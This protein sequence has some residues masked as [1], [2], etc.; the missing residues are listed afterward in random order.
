MSRALFITFEGGEGSGKTVQARLL[1]ERLESRGL[2]VLLTR[3]PGGT[4]LGDRLREILLHGRDIPLGAEAQALLFFAARAQLVRDVIRPAL[5][6]GTHV[7]GDRYYDSTLAYQG[8]GHGAHLEDL[9]ALARV[10]CG[11]LVPDMTILLDAPV[12]IGF[13]R[14]RAGS[15]DRFETDDA[16]FHRRVREGYLALARA[17]P[18]RFVVIGADRGEREIAREVAARVEAR[19]AAAP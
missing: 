16:A 17:E 7:I 8:Y 10:A 18:R 19:I 14:K 2:V 13:A 4:P 11:D 5:A 9:R 1:K 12:E 15:W 3:E 6:A